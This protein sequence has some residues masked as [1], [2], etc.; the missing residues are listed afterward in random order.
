MEG[1]INEDLRLEKHMNKTF[2]YRCQ[3]LRNIRAAFHFLDKDSKKIITLIKKTKTGMCRNIMV[4]YIKVCEE[5]RIQRT[6]TRLLETEDLIYKEI[7]CNRTAN[8]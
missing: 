1:K 2:G 7:K 6:T 8:T 5:I 3:M 4:P